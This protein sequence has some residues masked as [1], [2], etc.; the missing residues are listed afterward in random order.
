[1]ARARIRA[2]SVHL[3]VRGDSLML[4]VLPRRPFGSPPRAWRQPFSSGGSVKEFRFTSTC[5]ETAGLT[6]PTSQQTAVHLHVRG[7]SRLASASIVS[8]SGSPPR[9][10]RQRNDAGRHRDAPAVHL[11]VRGDSSRSQRSAKSENGSP[12]R[13]W[14]QLRSQHSTRSLSTVHLHVRGDRLRISDTPISQDGSPPRAWRQRS[15][16]ARHALAQRFTSTCVETGFAVARSHRRA[17]V[18]LH[19]RGDSLLSGRVAEVG[20]R[21]TSTCVETAHC[22]EQL[23]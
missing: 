13:A 4:L 1:M 2:F 8:R 7:D 14:R 12:P 17:A 20:Q 10:W 19:V 15:N 6:K 18:H 21:F 9:A 5:V 3:H 23:R 16:R 22:L 11:H